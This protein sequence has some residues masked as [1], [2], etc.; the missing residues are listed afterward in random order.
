MPVT[1]L[2]FHQLSFESQVGQIFRTTQNGKYVMGLSASMAAV[3]LA[4]LGQITLYF[5]LRR[6]NKRREAMT[7]EERVREN[8]AGKTGDFHPDY[9][10]TL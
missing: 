10:Y 1:A 6:E 4:C 2:Q 9:R 7:E 8:G 3:L 5:Y